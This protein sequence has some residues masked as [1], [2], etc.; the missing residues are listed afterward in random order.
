MDCQ[1]AQYFYQDHA[2]NE[3]NGQFL[4]FNKV[5]LISAVRRVGGV[6]SVSVCSVCVCVCVCVWE[7][8]G[9]VKRMHELI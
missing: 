2:E 9:G 1:L 6:Q 3:I 8:G 7:R 4:S 5:A